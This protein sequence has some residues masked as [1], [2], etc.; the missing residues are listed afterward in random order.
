MTRPDPRVRLSDLPTV[1]WYFLCHWWQGRWR[2]R[3]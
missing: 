1:A 2:G 3:K